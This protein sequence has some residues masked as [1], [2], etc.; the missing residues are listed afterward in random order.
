[1]DGTRS[2]TQF[3]TLCFYFSLLRGPRQGH[4]CTPSVRDS[5][6]TIYIDGKIFSFPSHIC[7]VSFK[8]FFHKLP[9]IIKP[10]NILPVLVSVIKKNNFRKIMI[11]CIFGILSSQQEDPLSPERRKMNQRTDPSRRP[12]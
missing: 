5:V 10:I 12:L 9:F 11:I 1:M 7:F 3:M 4:Q 2:L 8:I 6:I